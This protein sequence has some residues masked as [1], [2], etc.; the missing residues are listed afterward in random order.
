MSVKGSPLGAVPSRASAF[1]L[2]FLCGFDL[3]YLYPS[4]LYSCV[5][6]RL[7]LCI[8]WVY[9]CLVQRYSG[10]VHGVG[11]ALH[12]AACA[13]FFTLH[14]AGTRR[15]LTLFV[16]T[17]MTLKHAFRQTFFGVMLP[18]RMTLKPRSARRSLKKVVIGKLIRQLAPQI[19]RNPSVQPLTL[20]T[21]TPQHT[22]NLQSCQKDA[23]AWPTLVQTPS[24]SCS[25]SKPCQLALFTL[26]RSTCSP[27]NLTHRR[28]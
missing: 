21:A 25:M 19:P 16:P 15:E 22:S 13:Y 18:A 27:A 14:S 4:T 8:L 6:L 20:H 23:S 5:W 12:G 1:W 26:A 24:N 9:T 7:L 28:S 2:F 11:W 17:L 10:S 3:D